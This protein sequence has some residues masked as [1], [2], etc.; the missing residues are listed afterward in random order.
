[1]ASPISPLARKYVRSRAT[2]VMEYTCLIER[3]Q[4]PSYD[5]TTLV[6]APGSRET[7][8]EGICRIWEVSGA[9][10]VLV[11][12]NDITY[13]STQLSIPWDTSTVV[14]KGD[15]GVILTAP[16]DSQM[17]GKRFQ[18]D[19]VAKAGELRATRRFSITLLQA[20]K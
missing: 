9:S 16:A 18:I 20:Q 14:R 8:Y 10:T 12:E 17:V 4:K 15:E 5:N 6:A 7:L 19:T 2:A 1:M 11:G 13:Q 3:V